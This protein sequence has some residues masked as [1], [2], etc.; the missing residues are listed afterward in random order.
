M[1]KYLGF[2]IITVSILEKMVFISSWGQIT[3][4]VFLMMNFTHCFLKRLYLM[5]L[6]QKKYQI[7]DFHIY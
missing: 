6:Q 3:P 5:V 2:H 7:E 4:H 1:L